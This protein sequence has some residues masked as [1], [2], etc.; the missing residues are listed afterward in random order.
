MI[1]PTAAMLLV[2][3]LLPAIVSAGYV[4]SS[5]QTSASAT[6]HLVTVS[7]PLTAIAPPVGKYVA[8]I[9]L[10]PLPYAAKEG[11]ACSRVDVLNELTPLPQIYEQ[12]RSDVRHESP[13]TRICVWSK[14]NQYYSHVR[15][16][17]SNQDRQPGH[18]PSIS[19]LYLP[20]VSVDPV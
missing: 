7:I 16:S 10:D 14:D 3:Y 1:R 11:P 4:N 18:C 20:E 6:K 17:A 5:S 15:T 8:S 19:V 9:I 12:N 13:F 2:H